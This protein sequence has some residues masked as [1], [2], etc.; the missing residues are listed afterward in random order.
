MVVQIDYVFE[1]QDGFKYVRNTFEEIKEIVD[2]NY[3]A[4]QEIA[5]NGDSVNMVFDYSHKYFPS[6][7]I[8]ACIGGVWKYYTLRTEAKEIGTRMQG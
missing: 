8:S 2:K 7:R 1:C 3:K 6:A 4:L 5:S